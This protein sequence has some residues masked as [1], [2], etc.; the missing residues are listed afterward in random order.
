MTPRSSPPCAPATPR[1][2]RGHLRPRLQGGGRDAVPRHGQAGAGR[3]RTCR[4]LL[5]RA[6]PRRRRRGGLCRSRRR[7]RGRADGSGRD[8]PQRGTRFGPAGPARQIERIGPYEHVLKALAPPTSC[9]S[10][11][12]ATCPFSRTRFSLAQC[13]RRHR[14]LLPPHSSPRAFARCRSAATTRS[15]LPILKAVGAGRPVGMI[16]IDAHAD[17]SGEYEGSKDSTHGGPFRQRGGARRACLIP[18]ARS[19]S[20]SAARP[21]GSG[22]SPP[23]AG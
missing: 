12:S 11:T 10:P 3:S 17:T 13:H 7:P 1:Q 9:A 16:H 14:G 19:R 2:G 21:P 22:S 18:S 15:S 20:A 23:R 4:R 8:E 5:R 6:L